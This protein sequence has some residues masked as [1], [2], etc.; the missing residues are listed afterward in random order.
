MRQWGQS[1]VLAGLA[2]ASLTLFLGFKWAPSVPTSL[3]SKHLKRSEFSIG[4]SQV[5]GLQ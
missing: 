1:L 5:H 4:T 3:P 2:G